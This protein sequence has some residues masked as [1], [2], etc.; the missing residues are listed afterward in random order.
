MLYKNISI[1]TVILCVFASII[2]LSF[3]KLGELDIDLFKPLLLLSSLVYLGH[4][5]LRNKKIRFYRSSQRLLLLFISG[6]SLLST[7]WASN[8]FLA[9]SFSFGFSLFILFYILVNLVT[10]KFSD[11]QKWIYLIP[12]TILFPIALNWGLYSIGGSIRTMQQSILINQ[13]GLFIEI[14]ILMLLYILFFSKGLFPKIYSI[15]ILSVCGFGL[16]ISESRGAL[17]VIVFNIAMFLFFLLIREKKYKRKLLKQVVFFTIILLIIIGIVVKSVPVKN[18]EHYRARILGTF[19]GHDLRYY[20][21]Y[22]Y[23]RY[24]SRYAAYIAGLRMIKD[25]PFLGVGFGNFRKEFPKYTPLRFLEK[26]EI[27]PH[28]TYFRMLTELGPLGLFLFI[29]LIYRCLRDYHIVEKYLL[30]KKLLKKYFMVKAFEVTF[31]GLLL[32]TLF[33]PMLFEFPLYL[34]MAFSEILK[35]MAMKPEFLLS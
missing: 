26:V 10:S 7:F 30:K 14:S 16:I 28:N 15:G 27:D 4:N 32:H 3:I 2:P 8:P 31:W 19:E 5:A 1:Y 6:Y 35:R 20:N 22:Y 17:L 24:S 12:L 29:F 25:H 33:R 21:E 9:M 18:F 13:L 34:F 23:W 11:I